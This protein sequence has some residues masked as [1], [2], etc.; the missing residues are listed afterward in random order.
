MK[1]LD[2]ELP[3][4]DEDKN[5]TVI[6]RIRQI[7]WTVIIAIF[8]FAM[9]VGGGYW[10]WGQ[11]ETAE[12]KQQTE[13]AA[14]YEQVNPK[15]G[16]ALPVSYG[17]LGPRMIE[18]G[19]IDYDAFMGALSRGGDAVSNR[20][21]DIMKQGSDEQIV[22]TPE[23]AH[24]LLNYFWA[25]GL[26]NR[27]SIL[28]DGA[29][30]QYSEGQIETFASTGGWTLATKPVTEIYA[31]MDLISL[32]PEQQARVVDV[33]SAVYRPCCNNPTL[34]PDCNHGMAMLGLLEWMASNGATVDEMFEAAKYVNA[35]WF[36]QQN[37]EMAMYL[38]ANQKMEFKDAD[39]RMIVG[40]QFSS[41][42]GFAAVHQNLQTSGILP[43]APQQGGSCGS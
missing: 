30:V 4:E 3:S 37:L 35:F 2:S 9:G 11:D 29:M 40:A 8:A 21:I 42:S 12:W 5:Q 16:Y 6:N 38:K 36:P 32:T 22:I 1:E 15:D 25:V 34:F 27:N 39:A 41:G 18:A 10:Q 20:Q 17:D 24:F 13:M 23:N 26:A 7:A 19:V 33:A 28:T 31:S 43:Q 14:L